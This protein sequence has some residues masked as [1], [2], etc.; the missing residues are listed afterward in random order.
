MMLLMVKK[1]HGRVN[2]ARKL[3]TPSI[4]FVSQKHV[5]GYG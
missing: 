4:Q 5:E 1:F 2:L 3:L